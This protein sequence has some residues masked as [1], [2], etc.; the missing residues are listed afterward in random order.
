MGE[1]QSKWVPNY[2]RPYMV[3]IAFFWMSFNFN[4]Y[5]WGGSI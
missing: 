2:K 3:K 1:D 5:R 4:H